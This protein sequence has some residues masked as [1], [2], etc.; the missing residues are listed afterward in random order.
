MGTSNSKKLQENK[1]IYST[2]LMLVKI[3]MKHKYIWEKTYNIE[4]TLE[5]IYKDFITEKNYEKGFII[6]WYFN[7][8]CIEINSTKLREFLEL[9]NISNYSTIE[10]EQEINELNENKNSIEPLDYIAIPYINPFKILIYNIKQKTNNIQKFEDDSIINNEQIKFGVESVYCNGGN[11]FFIFGGINT[12]T[13]EELGMFLDINLLRGKIEYQINITPKKRNHGMIYNLK[14]VYIVGGNDQKTLYYDSDDQK[15]E[16][17][18]NLNIK[19]FEPSLIIHSNYLYCFDS[20]RNPENKYS[21]EKINLKEKSSW[22]I[23]YPKISN[24]LLENIYNQKYFGI[25][26]DN[27][28]NIIFIGGLYANANNNSEKIGDDSTIFNIKYNLLHNTMEKSDIPFQEINFSEKS[29]L[30]LNENEYIILLISLSKNLKLIEYYRDTNNIKI[31]EVNAPNKE[32]DTKKI[33]NSSIKKSTCINNNNLLEIELDMPGTNIKKSGL[34]INN[35]DLNKNKEKI[36]KVKENEII[37]NE[38]ENKIN[39]EINENKEDKIN[40]I[41]KKD[42][43]I[44]INNKQ[45]NEEIKNDFPGLE[46]NNKPKEI[47]NDNNK[48]LDISP[49]NNENI[50]NEINKIQNEDIITNDNIKTIVKEKIC[51]KIEYNL[52]PNKEYNPN[53]KILNDAENTNIANNNKDKNQNLFETDF[54]TNKKIKKKEREIIKNNLNEV[55]ENY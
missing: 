54:I 11:H 44:E 16:N 28:Y 19:R 46:I 32:Q 33:N 38:E 49:I 53:T 25:V 13:K 5:Q 34:K 21:F 17:L 30:P 27:N 41:I 26:E 48:I 2:F 50:H 1:K 12:K 29:L 52:N 18:G 35:V 3:V 36:I 22:E 10:F 9:N 6:K 14:K 15:I 42:N 31:T 24:E 43:L 8:K 4:I 23:L 37:N 40:S 7:K 47:N 39:N 55:E 51:D 45:N 20:T